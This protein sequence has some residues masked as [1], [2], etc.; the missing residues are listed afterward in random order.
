[1]WRSQGVRE[2][3]LVFVRRVTV[4]NGASGMVSVMFSVRVVS[5][6]VFMVGRGRW[7]SAVRG[8]SATLLAV[9][10]VQRAV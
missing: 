5:R 9:G 2:E 4:L 10:V 8:V 6:T 7:T 1:M 3:G